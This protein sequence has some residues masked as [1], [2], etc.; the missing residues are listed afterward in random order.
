MRKTYP[1]RPEGKHPDRVL[2]AVKHDIRKYIQRERRR[3]L[4]ADAHFWD[5][6]CRFGPT[7]AEAQTVHPAALIA[8]LDTLAKTGAEQCYVELLAKPGVRRPHIAGEPAPDADNTAVAQSSD[9]SIPDPTQS[10]DRPA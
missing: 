6:D 7:Q 8:E 3:E 9:G 4:P 1:L 10:T 5:F 2:E